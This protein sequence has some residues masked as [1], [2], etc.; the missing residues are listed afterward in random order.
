VQRRGLLGLAQIVFSQAVAQQ[1]YGMAENSLSIFKIN[2]EK[3]LR[4]WQEAA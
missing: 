2:M 1:M 3:I 4:F